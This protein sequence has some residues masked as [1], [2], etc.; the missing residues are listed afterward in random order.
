MDRANKQI[1]EN[2]K[3]KHLKIKDKK[4]RDVMNKYIQ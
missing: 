3:K 2:E 1:N 4:L